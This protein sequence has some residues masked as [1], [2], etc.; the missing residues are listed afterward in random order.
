MPAGRL[1]TWTKSELDY[2]MENA[3]LG[4]NKLSAD[5]GKPL[6]TV[7]DRAYILRISLKKGGKGSG[8]NLM[9]GVKRRPDPKPR[10]AYLIL[11]PFCEELLLLHP[12][13]L[14]GNGTKRLKRLWERRRQIIFKMHDYACYYCGDPADTIDHVKPRHLG[15]TDHLHNLVAAC[16]DCNYGWAQQIPWRD[17]YLKKRL[18]G[19]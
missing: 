6:N 3:H 19:V 8:R 12:N 16:R 5:L 4:A 13:A 9:P 7:R 11:N 10:S 15:G 17:K 18:Q 14:G 2:L 1:I